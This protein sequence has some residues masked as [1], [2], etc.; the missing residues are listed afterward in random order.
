MACSVGVQKYGV[1]ARMPSAPMSWACRASA[2]VSSTASAL[3]WMV[4]GTRPATT[5]TAASANN[6]RSSMVRLSDSPLWCGHEIAG[7]PARTWKS[8]SRSKVGRSRLKSSLSGV[9]GL[10]ITPRNLFCM[11]VLVSSKSRRLASIR[12]ADDVREVGFADR[13]RMGDLDGCDHVDGL[14]QIL[15]AHAETFETGRQSQPHIEIVKAA[16]RVARAERALDARHGLG[17]RGAV[18]A[19]G[20]GRGDGVRVSV[21]EIEPLPHPLRDGVLEPDLGTEIRREPGAV[22]HVGSGIEIARILQHTRQ[23][24]SEPSDR[25]LRHRLHDWIGV[26]AVKALHRMRH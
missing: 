16:R 8:S 14:G 3:T 6:L 1:I 10:C 23:A 26:D 5:L 13:P 7:A 25:F 11:T 12:L 15:L 20:V 2:I 21:V 22:E 9:T 18:E 4:T 17:C 24:C 19:D